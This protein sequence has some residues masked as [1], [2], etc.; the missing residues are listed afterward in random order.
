MP[1]EKN[2]IINKVKIDNIGYTGLT[3]LIHQAIDTKKQISIAYANAN[4]INLTYKDKKLI[5][6]LNSFDIIHPD[7]S[8]VYFASRYL[9]KD[10]GLQQKFTGSDL[11]PILAEYAINNNWKIFFF[12]HDDDTLSRISQ[13]IPGLIITGMHNGYVYN[14]LEIINQ[15][16]SSQ[17]DILIVGLGTPLQ[18]NWVNKFK[19]KL[20]CK[21]IICVGDGIKVFAGNK[22][23]GPTLLR[24]FGLEWLARYSTNPI[25]YFKRYI[26]GNPLFLYRI[27][28][29][30][31]RKL[32]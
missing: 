7:G 5:D 23:R 18:E 26:I 13:N 31:M 14:D 16:N 29:L 32:E 8:G 12:G 17:S 20:N 27:I 21:V 25:K 19:D 2:I 28:I 6:T 15:I 10:S 1:V 22:K 3:A 24:K 30:K 9:Y 4:T 11:Y